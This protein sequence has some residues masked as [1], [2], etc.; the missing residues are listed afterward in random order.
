M[1]Q[2]F[3]GY[4]YSFSES[5]DYEDT[6]YEKYEKIGSTNDISG[7]LAEHHTAS[8][9]I[10]YVYNYRFEI[11]SDKFETLK[12]L[13]NEIHTIMLVKKALH[14]SG[15]E[16][17]YKDENN[18]S[19]RSIRSFLDSKNV[20]NKFLEGTVVPKRRKTISK[21]STEEKNEEETNLVEREN[22]T[23]AIKM[24]NT[25]N[26]CTII[27][28]SGT[29]KTNI[30]MT[31]LKKVNTG[32]WLVL[33]PT[34]H[35]VKKLREDF[36]SRDIPCYS[37]KEQLPE[38]L[39][40]FCVIISTYDSSRKFEYIKFE[41]IIYDECH[42]T[43]ITKRNDNSPFQYVVKN[44]QANKHYFF[45]ATA[46]FLE[47]TKKMLSMDQQG[48]FGLKYEFSL[49][50]AVS[51]G[52]ICDYVIKIHS[53]RN[54]KEKIVSIFEDKYF[55]PNKA[56]IFCN[57]IQEAD[58]LQKYLFD[59]FKDI[60]TVFSFHSKTGEKI[61]NKALKCMKKNNCILCVCDM[62]SE[63]YDQP[64][65]DCVIHYS[66]T[67][68][69]VRNTQRN[70][71]GQ[72]VYPGK[73]N[74]KV[75]YF[76]DE[77]KDVKNIIDLLASTDYRIK[78][79]ETIPTVLKEKD[80][81]H[82]GGKLTYEMDIDEKL[83]QT[84]ITRQIVNLIMGTKSE[85]EKLRSLLWNKNRYSAVLIDR[86]RTIKLYQQLF[87]NTKKLCYSI[88][89]FPKFAMPTKIY[90]IYTSQIELNSV[91]LKK[92]CEQLEIDSLDKYKNFENKDRYRIPSYE[93]LLNG[94]INNVGNI[95]TFL[96]SDFEE[97]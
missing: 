95:T 52:Y 42:R 41:G 60:Y 18:P 75:Y 67:S 24:M 17:Y 49:D 13:E 93:F 5:P 32:K 20:E 44:F 89:D 76:I 21:Y 85:K 43:I 59:I 1:T 87:K 11:F 48:V 55:N 68:S 79:N 72:R 15:K 81:L 23:E 78:A 65:I 6:R 38:D 54:K 47:E 91:K 57:T 74:Y 9:C 96:G 36:S 27:S 90:K 28:P 77:L 84:E 12:Q 71:R 29:G 88:P 83:P 4:I 7:R 10:P 73:H 33:V 62:L 63:G 3:L 25:S 16:W 86:D 51:K 31:Y 2:K 35:L 37:Y 94:G 30:Y 46:K 45:T 69:Y 92:L 39:E 80:V 50:K 40:D 53:S 58:E 8:T 61:R 82:S 66:M 70:G 97:N 64:D 14:T 56:I 34:F 22:Q 26:R 19:Y